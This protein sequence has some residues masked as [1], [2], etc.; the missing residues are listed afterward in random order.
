V[1]KNKI[2]IA[3]RRRM[4]KSEL[5]SPVTLAHNGLKRDQTLFLGSLKSYFIKLQN[6]VFR[7]DSFFLNFFVFH[8]SILK[9]N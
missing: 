6:C 1:Q 4:G 8:P 5:L 7:Y 3:S 9:V 2:K